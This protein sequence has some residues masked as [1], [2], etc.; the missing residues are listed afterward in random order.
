M[1]DEIDAELYLAVSEASKQVDALDDMELFKLMETAESIRR[2]LTGADID[3]ERLAY[4][5]FQLS[6]EAKK[7]KKPQHDMAFA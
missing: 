4:L 3:A 5:M 2:Q 7:T 6:I 1:G